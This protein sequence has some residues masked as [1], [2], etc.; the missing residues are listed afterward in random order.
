MYVL[1]PPLSD[2]LQPCKVL[3]LGKFKADIYSNHNLL[4]ADIEVRPKCIRKTQKK[5]RNVKTTK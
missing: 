2:R 4:V 1:K 3:F 5:V